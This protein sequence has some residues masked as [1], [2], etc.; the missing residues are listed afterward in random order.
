ME[1]LAREVD[2]LLSLTSW[3]LL[4]V[5]FSSQVTVLRQTGLV[6]SKAGSGSPLPPL[7]LLQDLWPSTEELCSF[8]VHDMSCDCL[9]GSGGNIRFSW[10]LWSQTGVDWVGPCSFGISVWK[11]MLIFLSLRQFSLEWDF[12]LLEEMSDQD[13]LFSS[14]CCYKLLVCLQLLFLWPRFPAELMELV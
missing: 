7:P 2:A 4:R 6:S 14:S 3:E 5:K 1:L 12:F 8:S 11:L 10:C 13:V 9:R